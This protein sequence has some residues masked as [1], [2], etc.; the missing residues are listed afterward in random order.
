MRRTAEPDKMPLDA[1]A[2][3]CFIGIFEF[4]SLEFI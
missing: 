1:M 4:G 2:G 3:G